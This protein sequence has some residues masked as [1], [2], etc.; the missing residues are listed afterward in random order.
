MIPQVRFGCA[1]HDDATHAEGQLCIAHGKHRGERHE[2]N[3]R[4]VLHG[5]DAE[6]LEEASALHAEAVNA[7]QELGEMN[8][9][10]G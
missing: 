4:D 5:H 6:A 3:P 7:V 8:Q 9:C 2:R 1:I 10:R